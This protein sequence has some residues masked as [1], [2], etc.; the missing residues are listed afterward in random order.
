M[1]P[2]NWLFSTPLAPLH[3]KWRPWATLY[4][5]GFAVFYAVTFLAT[6]HFIFLGPGLGD[7]ITQ[8]HLLALLER[9]LY[10]DSLADTQVWFAGFATLVVFST[11]FRGW[12][13]Y[14]SFSH[15]R[16][17]GQGEFPLDELLLWQ[18]FNIMNALFLPAFLG[19]L[20][21]GAILLGL[22]PDT[23]W[24][25]LTHTVAQANRLVDAVPTLVALPS[26]LAFLCVLTAYSFVHYW[27]H[28]VCHT[29]RLLWLMLHRPHHMPQ[30]LSQ[31]TTL[32]VTMSFPFFLITAFPYVLIFGTLGKLFAEKPLYAE[33]ILFHLFILIGEIYGHAP[34]L[35]EKAIRNPLIRAISFLYC[36]GVYHVL[37]HSAAPWA[38][39]KANNNTVNIGAGLFC[40]WDILFGTYQPLTSRVPPIGLTGQPA[41]VKNPLRLLMAGPLQIAF[42]LW[43]NRTPMTWLQILLG[44][45]DYTPPI[46]KDF[47]LTSSLRVSAPQTTNRT[48]IL[49]GEKA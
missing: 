7:T 42:E 29:R 36:Q 18:L 32:P 46:S 37:H 10:L 12:V 15:Y 17:L 33:F 25:L 43:H 35:Y 4:V 9:A 5:A 40:L 26:W 19:L 28:R 3:E 22:T 31:P 44:P 24:G 2:L 48:T 20:A 11:G 49:N 13:A 23:G 45:S 27:A 41:L 39:R 14:R 38:T 16:D 1:T 47:T 6:L 8:D 21:L 34:A 30:H